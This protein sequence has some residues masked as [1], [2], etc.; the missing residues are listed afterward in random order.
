MTAPPAEF[1]LRSLDATWDYG[2][3]MALPE[4]GN[5]YEVIDGVLYMT[6]APS[7]FHGWIT[8]RLW[9]FVGIPTEDAGVAFAY[10]APIGVLMP[11]CDPVQPNFLLVRQERAAII[12][13]GR[14]YGPPDLIVEILSPSNP[15]HDTETKRRAYARAEVPEYWIIRPAT[16]DLLLYAQPEPGAGDYAQVRTLPADATLQ[17]P[18]LPLRVA[19]ADLF[20]G[21]PDRTL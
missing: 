3:W 4:D 12:R 14:I 19:C 8:G 20:A 15:E 10:S 2:R 5:R 6:T 7:S 1:V 17:S 9:R 21:A 11:G 16:N 18:T 13:D